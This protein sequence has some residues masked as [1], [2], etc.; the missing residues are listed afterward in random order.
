MAIAGMNARAILVQ[1][2]ELLREQRISRP[3]D[4]VF[5]FFANAK[6]LEAITPLWL[7]FRILSPEPIAMQAGARIVYRLYWRRLPL[8]WVSEIR[9]W[10]P[11]ASFTDVQIRGPYS[12]WH[13]TH[14]FQAVEGGT[15]IRDAVEYS[16]PFGPLGRIAHIAVVKANLNAIFD[17]RAEKVSELLEAP[18][19]T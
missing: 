13:H 3:I 10:N 17:Y 6:N 1:R 15:L 7:G 5:A 12:R 18:T 16:L 9:S 14:T 2:L 8:R 19:R 11:P 4:D